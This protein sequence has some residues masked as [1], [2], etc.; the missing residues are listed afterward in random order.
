M[1][2]GHWVKG[3]GAAARLGARMGRTLV[4]L[5]YDVVSPYSWLGF[6]VRGGEEREGGRLVAAGGSDVAPSSPRGSPPGAGLA[7]RGSGVG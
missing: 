6:E 7:R 2:L 5:F 3:D 1:P 4:E